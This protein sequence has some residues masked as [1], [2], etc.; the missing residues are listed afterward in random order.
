[1]RNLNERIGKKG[2]RNTPASLGKKR[3]KKRL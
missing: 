1:M 2:N 3:A